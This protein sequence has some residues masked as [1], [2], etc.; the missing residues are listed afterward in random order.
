MDLEGFVR[1]LE[2][3]ERSSATVS[4]YTRA[5]RMYFDTHTEL[6]K[7]GMIEYKRKMLEK[8][9]S[10]TADVRCIAMNQYCKYAG[11]PE[12]T[13]KTVKRQRP[14]SGENV[15][16]LDEYNY[17]LDCLKRDEKESGY[18]MV[19]YLAK[20]GVRVSELVRMKVEDVKK[21]YFE[22]LTKRKV[23]RIYLPEKLIEES[24]DY[25]N[26]K[27]RGFV[28]IGRYGKPLTKEAV[29]QRLQRY[30][31]LYGIRK[32]V[33]HPHSFRH[34]YAIQFLRNDGDLSLLADLMGHSD[35]ATTVRYTQLTAKEQ[36]DRLNKAADK[37]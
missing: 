36:R 8:Y 14:I 27:D 24:R 37:W 19:K 12:C 23:R 32:E 7:Q 6:S 22:I 26:T 10:A 2:E 4:Q 31:K 3:A 25:L 13:V 21:G 16:S 29:R 9:S 33:M 11:R 30:A 5:V 15:I 1:W 18:W 28:F 20:T 35:I 34:L 17:L